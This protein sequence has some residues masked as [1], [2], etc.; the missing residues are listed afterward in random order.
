MIRVKGTI[1]ITDKVVVKIVATKGDVTI[2][3]VYPINIPP[4][5]IVSSGY[6]EF[7]INN[8]IDEHIKEIKKELGAEN[9]PVLVTA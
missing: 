9:D 4:Q 2:E 1:H 8:T 3:K 5:N 6:K 7:I